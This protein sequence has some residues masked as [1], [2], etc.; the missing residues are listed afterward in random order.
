MEMGG[1]LSG[2][3]GWG[4][5]RPLRF[6]IPEKRPL[7]SHTALAVSRVG[8]TPTPKCGGRPLL[9]PR[10]VMTFRGASSPP[11]P[12][13]SCSSPPPTDTLHWE[14]VGGE[15]ASKHTWGSR[16]CASRWEVAASGC[17]T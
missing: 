7:H 8:W 2:S 12:L 5:R 17:V 3:E 15:S 13:R 4:V 1:L 9:Q 16:A 10:K 6:Q 11:A 14:G